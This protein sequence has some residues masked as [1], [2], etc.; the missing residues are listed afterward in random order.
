MPAFRLKTLKSSR[1]GFYAVQ[2][3]TWTAHA[4][5][6]DREFAYRDLTEIGAGVE[7]T[8]ITDDRF[9]GE[10]LSA[11]LGKLAGVPWTE[12]GFADAV[13]EILNSEVTDHEGCRGKTFIENLLRGAA[14]AKLYRTARFLNITD[15]AGVV[16]WT[17]QLI[18][19]WYPA[20][21]RKKR[22]GLRL[23][24]A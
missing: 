16:K 13:R 4:F 15:D 14:G 5:I 18:R 22:R 1:R 21:H 19:E 6:A 10:L 20:R 11:L 9:L 2:F 3:P 17:S 23:T 24:V 7:L 8:S 12:A